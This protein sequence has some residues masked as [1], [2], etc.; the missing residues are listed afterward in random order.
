MSSMARQ[1][2][3][4]PYDWGAPQSRMARVGRCR[5]LSGGRCPE[6]VTW[7]MSHGQLLDRAIPSVCFVAN[8]DVAISY[9]G[10]RGRDRTPTPE[11]P[12]RSRRPPPEKRG[13][14]DER[15]EG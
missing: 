15:Q 9:L 5:E 8:A 1:P 7:P 6:A 10:E 3:S 13:A 11:A 2:Y 4:R 12:R 14:R